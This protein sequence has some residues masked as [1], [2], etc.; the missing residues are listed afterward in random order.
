MRPWIALLGL[1]LVTA[2]AARA[3][4]SADEA[5]RL[6]EEAYVFAYATAEHNKVLNA[7]AAKLPYN[8]LFSEPRLQ[9][10]SLPVWS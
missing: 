1:A 9:E 5:R 7:I 8:R 3:A 2:S 6:A 10:M 4:P